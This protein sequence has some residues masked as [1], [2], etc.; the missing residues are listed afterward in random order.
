[1]GR[2]RP[3]VRSHLRA[4]PEAVKRFS[5]L[6]VIVLSTLMLLLSPTARAE[7]PIKLW[8][9]YRGAEQKALEAILAG[10]DGR[11]ELLGVPY[12]AF[13]S[14]LESSI[15]LGEGPDL[16]IDA[17]ERRGDY[18]QRGIVAPLPAAL[19]DTLAPEH[20][21]DKAIAAVTVDA[22]PLALPLSQKCLALYV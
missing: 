16:Y 2:A 9:A 20:Y 22:R 5:L 17:P 3:S 4:E 11:V 13:A 7:Q 12:D 8:H 19:A 18:H 14:K 6:L 21:L 15:P 10:F 1:S